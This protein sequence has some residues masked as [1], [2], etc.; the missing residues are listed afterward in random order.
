MEVMIGLLYVVVL[1]AWL[2]SLYSTEKP[3]DS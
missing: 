2:V 1:I 3:E